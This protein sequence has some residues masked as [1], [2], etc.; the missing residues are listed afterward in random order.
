MSSKIIL[1]LVAVLVLVSLTNQS[2][3]KGDPNV[4]K[5]EKCGGKHGSCG[6]VGENCSR[7]GECGKGTRPNQWR[8]NY[9]ACKGKKL[10]MTLPTTSG[11]LPPD[12]KP[13]NNK[14]LKNKLNKF[15]A[16]IE[17]NGATT[18]SFM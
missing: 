3:C 5:T 7:K 17:D 6:K 15:M 12:N 2:G 16:K 8:Y 14:P 1:S 4:S 13:L 10:A 9:S 18:E 11:I